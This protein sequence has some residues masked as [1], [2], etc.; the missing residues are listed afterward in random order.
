MQATLLVWEIAS[1]RVR[2]TM[3]VTLEAA[4]SV[5]I[6]PSGQFIAIGTRFGQIYIC[7]LLSCQQVSHLQAHHGAIS[8]LRFGSTDRMLLSGSSDTTATVWNLDSILSEFIPK[9]PRGSSTPAQLDK[10]WKMLGSSDANVAYR[11]SYTLGN[12]PKETIAFLTLQCTPIPVPDRQVLRRLL[13]ELDDDSYLSRETAELGIRKFGDAALPM[14]H[15]VLRD[16]PSLEARTRIQRVIATLEQD[17]SGPRAIR[18]CRVLEVLERLPSEDTYDLLNKLAHG[19]VDARLT[20]EA[21]ATLRRL[22][23]EQ[24]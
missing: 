2:A 24:R 1:G 12:N 8:Y 13:D 3:E 10:V 17:Q 6:S 22:R 20:K 9:P 14:L 23:P 11:A 5:T 15:H 19:A 7:D 16:N 18:Y 4:T 21:I